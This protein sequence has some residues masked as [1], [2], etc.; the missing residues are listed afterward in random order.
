VGLTTPHRKKLLLRNVSKRLG[1]GRI[2]RHDLSN[3]NLRERERER[4]IY[5][6]WGELDSAGS[7]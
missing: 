6:L 3:G 1:S 4:E 2:F 5:D 7:E